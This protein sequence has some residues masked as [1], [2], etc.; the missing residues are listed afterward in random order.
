LIGIGRILKAYPVKILRR[1]LT[2]ALLKKSYWLK[3]KNNVW[4]GIRHFIV[5]QQSNKYYPMPTALLIIIK[6]FIA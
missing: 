6:R 5:G 3:E 4:S 2:I 1:W